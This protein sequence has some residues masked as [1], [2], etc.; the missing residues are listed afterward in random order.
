MEDGKRRQVYQIYRLQIEERVTPAPLPP[1]IKSSALDKNIGR[2][3]NTREFRNVP[4]NIKKM[5]KEDFFIVYTKQHGY[6]LGHG[7]A[8]ETDN[9]YLLLAKT[10][11]KKR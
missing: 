2:N 5:V 7:R 10:Y 9:V 8:L 1:D 11:V 3:K 4:D 6:P